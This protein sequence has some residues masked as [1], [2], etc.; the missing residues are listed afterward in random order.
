MVGEDKKL[1]L[2][3]DLGTMIQGSPSVKLSTENELP[4]PVAQAE[5]EADLNEEQTDLED[6]ISGFTAYPVARL[7]VTYKIF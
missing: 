3:L 5:L 4:N 6:S 1:G 7:A 2:M